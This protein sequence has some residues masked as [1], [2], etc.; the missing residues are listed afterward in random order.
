MTTLR[1]C[2]AQAQ[3]DAPGTIIQRLDGGEPEYVP[4][5]ISELVF[6]PLLD[7]DATYENGKIYVDGSPLARLVQWAVSGASLLA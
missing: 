4:H 7:T 5:S 2:L 3:Q 1:D 6:A